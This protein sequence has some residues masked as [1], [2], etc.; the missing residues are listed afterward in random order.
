MKINV[1]PRD[2]LPGDRIDRLTPDLDVVMVPI[3]KIV[4]Q[5]I[6]GVTKSYKVYLHDEDDRPVSQRDAALR[7]FTLRV[8][9]RV[10]V[11]REGA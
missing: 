6:K 10:T 4:A 7:P 8:S 2:L 11:E 1:I 5:K 9:Q 3:E